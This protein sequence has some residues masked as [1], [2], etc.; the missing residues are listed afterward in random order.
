MADQSKLIDALGFVLIDTFSLYRKTHIY[1]WNVRGPDF[2]QLHKLFEKQ[3]GEIWESV[4]VI[5]EHIRALGA[6]TPAD[7]S[8]S[9]MSAAI[10]TY[11]A[12]EMVTDLLADN[13]AMVAN[14]ISRA[15]AAAEAPD[16][17]GTLNLLAERIDAHR[18]HAWMLRA[19]LGRV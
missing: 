10:P 2:A 11:T 5:A 17:Q 18:K 1:H 9:A 12:Q 8:G 7:F 14:T 16:D 15:V 3:Y 13:V 6:L 4:D 19:T